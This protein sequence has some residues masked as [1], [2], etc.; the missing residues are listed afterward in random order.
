MSEL[1]IKSDH[2]KLRV[3]QLSA[4]K[5]FLSLSDSCFTCSIALTH[6][7]AKQVAEYL[8]QWSEKND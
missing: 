4:A 2:E 8:L 5:V 6:E 1:L 7:Q 3:G